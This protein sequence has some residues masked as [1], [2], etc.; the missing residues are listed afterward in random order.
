MTIRKIYTGDNL[1][2]MQGLDAES[3]DLIYLDPPFNSNRDYAAPITLRES[4]YAGQVAEFV[5]TWEYTDKDAEWLFVIEREEPAVHAV[6]QAAMQSHSFRMGGYLCMM[7][8]RILEMRRLMKP[9]AS[10]YL[11]CDPTASHYLKAVMDAV[12]GQKQFRNEIVWHYKN[13]SRG[14]KQRAKAHDVMLLYVKTAGKGVFNREDVLVPYESGMTAWRYRK[15]GKTPP[16][17]KTPD[18][19]IT[20]PSLNTMDK[21]RVGYPT[22][23]PLKLLEQIIKA[24]SNPGDVVLDP[25]AGCATA[26]V[27]A[28]RLGRQWIGIDVSDMAGKL[29]IE[30]L[31]RE[32]N[33]ENLPAFSEYG[34]VFNPELVELIQIRGRAKPTRYQDRRAELYK[35]QNGVCAGCKWRMPEHS[36][37]VDHIKPRSKGGADVLANLQLLCAGCNGIK[38]VGTMA[39]LKRALKEKDII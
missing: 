33:A 18:D 10:I 1:A 21:E 2:V 7:A 8:A 25:F 3:V 26:C 15:K 35:H 17:G 39:N 22:Q 20:M 19:V 38:G 37:A 24:S 23:K 14:T 6:I 28:E 32:Y 29:V 13:A 12:F 30:R 4:E 9:T 5:D 16:K 34:V 31:Q 36:M 27:A 11:H